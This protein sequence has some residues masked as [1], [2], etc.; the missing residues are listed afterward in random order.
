M[1]KNIHSI[2]SEFKA[3]GSVQDVVAYGK[4]HINDTFLVITQDAHKPNYILQRINHDIFQ[5]IPEMM[6]NIRIVTEHLQQ[7][8]VHGPEKESNEQCLHLIE[9]NDNNSFT[10]DQDGNYWRCLN[11]I[12]NAIIY[13]KASNPEI[14]QQAGKIIG[15]FQSALA[16]LDQKLFETLPKFHNF[17]RRHDEYLKAIATNYGNRSE[18]VKGELEF[19]DDRLNEMSEYYNKLMTSNIPVRITHND[20][21]INNIIFN[22]VDKAICLIDFDTVM[23]GYVH[24]DYGD[25][26]RTLANTGD[27]DEKDLSKVNFS[28]DLFCSFTKGYLEA[29]RSFLLPEE[30]DLLPFAPRYLTFLIGLRFLNDYLCGDT[31]FK[32]SEPDHNLHRAKA[33]FKLLKCM[34]EQYHKMSNFIVSHK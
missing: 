17:N 5:H 10:Q 26:L 1:V 8:K 20:T 4:G 27:E 12:E 13:E 19:V 28:F 33:Q 30:K 11:F 32:T 24:Y 16:N 14:A 29:A 21:K 3:E 25:A 22:E 9:T 15:K 31:Y 23:P 18:R 7:E 2:F 6:D 34:E